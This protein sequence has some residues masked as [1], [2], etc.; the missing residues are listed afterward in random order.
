[1]QEYFDYL[2][3]H[4]P[5]VN[6][7]AYVAQGPVRIDEM[8]FSKEAATPEQ[9]ENMKAEVRKAMEAGCV[10]MSYGSAG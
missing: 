10:A 1:M 4:T 5:A 2:D 7:V 8:G 6:V 9:L 3:E